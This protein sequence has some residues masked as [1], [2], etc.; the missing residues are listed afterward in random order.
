MYEGEVLLKF[1]VAQHFLFG[2]LFPHTWELS[3]A[4]IEALDHPE[5]PSGAAD[6]MVTKSPFAMAAARAPTSG[7]PLATYFGITRRPLFAQA[8]SG[9]HPGLAGLHSGFGAAQGAALRHTGA[10]PAHAL[11]ASSSSSSPATG[12][13]AATTTKVPHELL[14]G[15]G[16]KLQGWKIT[17]NKTRISSEAELD[18]AKESHRFRG[19]APD[20]PLPEMLFGQNFCRFEHAASGLVIDLNALDAVCCCKIE[21]DANGEPDRAMFKLPMAD[22]WANRKDVNGTE[23]KEWREDYD[24][25]LTSTYNGTFKWAG[26]SERG[27]PELR[28]TDK[29][30]NYELLKRRDPILFY[31]SLDLYEDDLFDFGESKFS[32]KLRVMPLCFFALARCW[33]RVDGTYMRSFDTRIFHEFGT[34]QVLVEVSKKECPISDLRVSDPRLLMDADKAEPLLPS[35]S[36]QTFELALPASG[37]SA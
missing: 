6:G 12:Q 37:S 27:A 15:K 7:D 21:H 36:L 11:G 16:I 17:T 4:E 25:T 32:V 10:G 8:G 35:T 1:P 30:I 14:Q 28:A 23:I 29:K 22:K 24:W 5:N 34:S 3:A 2:P 9:A 13:E 20:F 18:E 26:K 31:E 19:H 33:L